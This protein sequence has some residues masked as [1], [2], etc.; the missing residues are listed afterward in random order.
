M[1]EYDKSS[2]W[3]IQHFAD[4]ILR[5]FGVRGIVSWRSLQTDFV[6]PRRIPDGFIEVQRLGQA[7]PDLYILEVATY[8]EA[9]VAHQ[10]L[11]DTAMV[12]LDRH[13]LPEVVVLFLRREGNAEALDALD[14][15]SPQGLTNLKFT[16]RVA[17]L[18]EVPAQGLLAAGDI[19]LIPWVP[20]TKFRGTPESMIRQCRARI[21]QVTSHDEHENL[22][23]VTQFLARVRYTDPKLFEI[24]GGLETMIKSPLFQELKAEWTQEAKI[25]GKIEAKIEALMTVLV[26]RFG[27]KAKALETEIKAINDETRLQELL[28]HA[29]TCRTLGS[30]RKQLAL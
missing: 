29:A 4:S 5:L 6:Q 28:E 30:F 2:K 24:L 25:E 18:W 10:V 3:L 22:L 8:P 20:L 13:V 16:W 14:L 23:A 19:G 12:Y 27:S 17:K 21:D 1:H 7:T 9:R 11:A 26:G 15:S